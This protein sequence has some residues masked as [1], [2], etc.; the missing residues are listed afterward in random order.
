MVQVVA[1]T[2]DQESKNF[3]VGHEL[4]HLAGFKHGEHGLGNVQCVS[5]IMILDWPKNSQDNIFTVQGISKIEA[6]KFLSISFLNSL[7]GQT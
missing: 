3:K 4:F 5:P 2:G 7:L 1:Q 6:R